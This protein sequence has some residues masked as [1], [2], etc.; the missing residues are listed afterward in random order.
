M[1]H[2]CSLKRKL[3]PERLPGLRRDLREQMAAE[4]EQ[5]R[6]RL[7]WLQIIRTVP[8]S[9]FILL[10]G[11]V[12]DWPVPVL[13]PCVVRRAKSLLMSSDFQRC[14]SINATAYV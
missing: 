14:C 7:T 9:C 8:H 2:G 3:K 5:L 6:G 12:L 1:S 11:T 4:A 10:F 13:L